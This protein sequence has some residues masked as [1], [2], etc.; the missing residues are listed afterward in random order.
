MRVVRHAKVTELEQRPRLVQHPEDGLLTPVHADGGDTYVDLAAVDVDLEL[1]V[2]WP[3]ALDDVHA[4]HDLQAR[5]QRGSHV[6]GKSQH[7]MERAVDAETNPQP[8]VLR[9][10]VHIGST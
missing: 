1:T 6:I 2:L 4:G 8:V 9:L 10:D 7:V 5:H 3:A